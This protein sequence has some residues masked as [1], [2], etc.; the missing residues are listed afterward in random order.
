MVKSFKGENLLDKSRLM[1]RQPSN[2]RISVICAAVSFTADAMMP[3][4]PNSTS[5]TMYLT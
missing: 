1:T 4:V 3:L 2:V 5:D